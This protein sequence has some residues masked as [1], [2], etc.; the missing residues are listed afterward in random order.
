MSRLDDIEA[1]LVALEA[2]A[3]NS[4]K[5]R[6]QALEDLLGLKPSHDDLRA[7]AGTQ[8]CDRCGMDQAPGF[9]CPQAKCPLK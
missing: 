9:T 6:I 1:R 3:G 7:P 8:H 5:E 2:A 4:L